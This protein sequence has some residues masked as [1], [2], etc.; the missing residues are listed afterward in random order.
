M[1]RIF[2]SS[3]N[4]VFTERDRAQAVVDRLNAEHPGEPIFSL[5]RWEESFYT[6]TGTF[7]DQIASPGEHALVIFIFWKR[8]GTDLPERYN[9][10]DGT[11]RTGTEYEFEE[12]RD[13]RDRRADGLPDIL[14]YR[15]TA[16]VL[17]SEEM[18]ETERAQKKALDQ[19]WERWFRTDTGH[20]IAGFQSF[21]TPGDFDRKLEQNLREWLRRRNSGL[22]TWDIGQQG[23]PYRGL[24]PFEENHAGLFFGRDNDIARARARFIEASVG[25]D[26]GRRGTAFLLVLGASGSGKSSFMRAGLIPRMR[27]AGVPAFLEDG[28]DAIHSFRTLTLIPREIGTDL[29]SG[30]AAALYQRHP[31]IQ[32]AHL[33]L[34]ELAEGDYPSADDFAVLARSSPDSAVAPVLRGLSR[35]TDMLSRGELDAG[36]LRRVGL[37]VAIDQLEELFARS[38]DDR[39]QFVRLLSALAATGRVWVV[40]T[41]RNDFYDRLRQDEE[42]SGLA[43]RG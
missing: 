17:F 12:A 41:L 35:V 5:T 8:L 24:V 13:A 26:S 27:A 14:V 40:A 42:L 1:Y 21:A 9:R 10:A 18:L 30:L 25:P 19:F 34:P 43:D 33:G 28:S 3:P 20:F 39:R 37:L 15:K 11:S 7:Q 38:N 4:D 31:A 6:A 22:P 23:S 16:K 2:L 36:S 29:C 32:D